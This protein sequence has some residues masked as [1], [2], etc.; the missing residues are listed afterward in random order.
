MA[1]IATKI[2]ARGNS[3]GITLT[4]P[5]LEVAGLKLNDD[6][7]VESRD[8]EIVIRRSSQLHREFDDAHQWMVGRYGVTLARLAK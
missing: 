1:K 6:V 5:I 8:G 3:A 4:Q 2:T 7:Q